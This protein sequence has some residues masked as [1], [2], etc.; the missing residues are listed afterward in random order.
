MICLS[1]R[2]L[3]TFLL[4]AVIGIALACGG[5]SG[6]AGGGETSEP[7]PAPRVILLEMHPCTPRMLLDQLAAYESHALDGMCLR[8]TSTKA[9]F[10]HEAHPETEYDADR[11]NLVQ[12]TRARFTSNVLLFRASGE[13]GWDWFSEAD[14]AAVDANVR[15]QAR[16]AKQGG[17][18]ALVLDPENYDPDGLNLW[19]HTLQPAAATHD[20]ASMRAQVK[21]RGAQFMQAV[22]E[23]CPGLPVMG[24]GLASF[25]APLTNFS[26]AD[27]VA[28]WPG[29]GYGLL[30]AFTEGMAS[31][32][33]KADLIDGVEF[34]YEEVLPA[35]FDQ[36]QVTVG[37]RVLRLMDDAADKAAYQRHVR[38]AP[39]VYVDGVMNLIASAPGEFHY[40][41][42]WLDTD[43][44]RLR[45]LENNLYQALRVGQPFCWIYTEKPDW[46]TGAQ[47]PE[48]IDSILLRCKEKLRRKQPLGFESEVQ[49]LWEMVEARKVASAGV[50]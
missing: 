13:A 24:L 39:A 22:Q 30:P 3:S 16:L 26:D 38:V 44:Q 46:V 10:S 17:L 42:W 32:C 23:E 14:W 49:A 35:R 25:A 11:A 47:L 1:P 48:G 45:I 41:G 29:W 6:G 20:L 40:F 50:R 34:T 37:E 33:G 8:T 27:L 7:P 43:A 2:P 12:L 15:V 31:T 4:A 21:K 36:L 28:R 9:V 18:K 19:Q 5:G